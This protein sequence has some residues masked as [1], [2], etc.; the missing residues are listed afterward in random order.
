MLD[1]EMKK[2]LSAIFAELDSYYL[3]DVVVAS[4]HESRE[5]IIDSGKIRSYSQAAALRFLEAAAG[6]KK[7]DIEPDWEYV[8]NDESYKNYGDDPSSG[9]GH[10][11]ICFQKVKGE[12]SDEEYEKWAAKVFAVT[13]AISDDGHNIAGYEFSK[14]GEDPLTPVNFETAMALWIPGWCYKY[15]G[16]YMTVYVSTEYDENKESKKGSLLYNYAVTADIGFGLQK[17]VSDTMMEQK[18]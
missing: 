7:S 16:K 10:G 1:V 18:E 14:E 11:S 9:F 4:N 13:A 17:S 15:N 6:I 8:I 3:L 12:V 5:E 2:Q